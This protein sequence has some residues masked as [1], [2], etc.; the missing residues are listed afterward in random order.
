M[1]WG[2][3]KG[4]TKYFHVLPVSDAHG[5]SII[6]LVCSLPLATWA[7]V[8]TLKPFG[9]FPLGL[10]HLDLYLHIPFSLWQEVQLTFHLPFD[11]LTRDLFDV[12]T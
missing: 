4:T 8:L 2:V 12:A 10:H 3:T 5:A 1:A 9:A 6:P 11:C 7:E